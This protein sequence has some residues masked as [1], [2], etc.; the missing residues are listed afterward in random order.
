MSI[1]GPARMIVVLVMALGLGACAKDYMPDP[2][3]DLHGK[4]VILTERR[5]PS[6]GRPDGLVL[7]PYEYGKTDTL[8]SF[9]T[10]A[11]TPASQPG[12]DAARKEARNAL[13]EAMIIASDYNTNNHLADV[14]SSQTTG[15]LILGSVSLGL[16]AAAAVTTGGATNALA[17]ASTGTQ[18]TRALV[19]EQVWRE[20]FA[21]SVALLVIEKRKLLAAEIRQHYADSIVAY[22]IERGWA[23]VMEYHQ[24]GSVYIGLAL[25]REAIDGKKK[26]LTDRVEKVRAFGT[27]SPGAAGPTSP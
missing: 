25:A 9:Y 1:S 15:N 8:P 12:D 10:I 11:S 16:T 13:I 14:K 19:T 17:A 5:S 20:T 6:W 3:L 4:E 23:E 24:T 21:E 2:I 22:P 27:K 26:E 18:G 7:N